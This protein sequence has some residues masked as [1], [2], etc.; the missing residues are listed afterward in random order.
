M[1]AYVPP[2]ESSDSD[3]DG[4]DDGGGRKKKKKRD[5]NAPKRPNSS[6]L[7]YANDT[8]EAVRTAHLGGAGGKLRTAISL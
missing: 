8:R 3:G 6:F 7:L 4:S 2:V 5:P 1:A